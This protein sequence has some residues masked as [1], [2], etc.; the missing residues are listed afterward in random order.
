MTDGKQATTTTKTEA[1]SSAPPRNDKK[2][3]RMMRVKRTKAEA[4]TE[5]LAAPE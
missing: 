3:V 2:A 5:I 1:D 4:D